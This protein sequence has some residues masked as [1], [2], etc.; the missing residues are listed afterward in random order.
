M[1]TAGTTP[2][3]SAMKAR[4]MSPDAILR[5]FH[6]EGPPVP[7][8][9]IIANMGIQ[10]LRPPNPGWSGAVASDPQC[11]GAVIW[12]AAEE[13]RFRSRFT[14][15]HELGHLM[16]HDGVQFRDQPDFGGSRQETQA[17]RFAADLLMPLWMLD[18]YATQYRG[19]VATLA[20]IFD[21]SEQA[22]NIRLG[23]LAGW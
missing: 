16:L 14:I 10:V 13:S 7:I 15:A 6:V 5:H 2:V 11:G 21:V 1:T 18:P 4:R 12:V 9:N 8:E 19:D 22:M 17:N 3:W 23:K 20:R